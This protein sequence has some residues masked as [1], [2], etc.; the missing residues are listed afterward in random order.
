MLRRRWSVAR[1][2]SIPDRIMRKSWKLLISIFVRKTWHLKIIPIDFFKMQSF[3]TK[4]IHHHIILIPLSLILKQ[5]YFND[6]FFFQSAAIYSRRRWCGERSKSSS[7]SDKWFPEP[8]PRKSPLPSLTYPWARCRWRRLASFTSIRTSP[9][10]RRRSSTMS[11]RGAPCWW[12]LRSTES[13][14]TKRNWPSIEESIWRYA[15]RFHNSSKCLMITCVIYPRRDWRLKT[16]SNNLRSSTTRKTGGSVET[17]SRESATFLTPFSLSYRRKMPTHTYTSTSYVQ[18][19]LRKIQV[20]PNGGSR[21]PSSQQGMLPDDAP[22][23][24]KERQGKRGEFRYFWKRRSFETFFNPNNFR[25]N[26]I[27]FTIPA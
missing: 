5:V 24:V 20:V 19:R 12:L 2:R 27:C 17:C 26:W 18:I 8:H 4:F 22:P 6:L 25:V 16:T 14:R 13:L 11:L 10:G 3:L 21:Q 15:D 9:P 7:K 1:R 23:Y